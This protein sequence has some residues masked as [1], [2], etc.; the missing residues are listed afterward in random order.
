MLEPFL[1]AAGLFGIGLVL[2][3]IDK[4][5]EDKMWVIAGLVILAIIFVLTPFG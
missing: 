2:F 3:G 5:E 4:W 1:Y